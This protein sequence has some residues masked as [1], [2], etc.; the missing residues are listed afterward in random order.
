M[1][2]TLLALVSAAL[3]AIAMVA[4]ATAITGNYVEDFDHPFVG[5][6]AFYS[7][8][9]E[10]MTGS[11]TAARARSWTTGRRPMARASS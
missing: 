4:P 10:R 3:M 1:R 5:L 9:R 8:A 2:R 11:S 6:I 7:D